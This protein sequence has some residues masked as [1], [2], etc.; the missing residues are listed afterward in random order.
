MKVLISNG[1]R[2]AHEII[3]EQTDVDNLLTLLSLENGMEFVR[4][5]QIAGASSEVVDELHKRA[6]G[7]LTGP[8]VAKSS[9][10]PDFKKSVDAVLASHIQ[11]RLFS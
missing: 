11:R 3:A 1:E 9:Q 4:E 10:N 5:V 2:R 6:I 7:P 8:I